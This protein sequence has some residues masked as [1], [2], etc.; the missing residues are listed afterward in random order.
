MKS[1]MKL[2]TIQS[3]EWYEE[4]LRKGTI[5]GQRSCI[6]KNWEFCLFGY[7]WLMQKMDERIGKRPN[8]DCY[9]V[10][11]WYQYFDE[12]KKKPD[13]RSRGFIPKGTK[14][15]RIEFVK[16]DKDVLLSDFMLWSF[17]FSY[18]SY[19]G[20]NERESLDFDK[21]LHEK[22]LYY[23]NLGQLPKD[24]RKEIVESWD[25]VLDLDYCDPYHASP[26]A[27]KSIQATF[28]TL[29]VDEIIKVEEF[30]AH[31]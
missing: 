27:K 11:A 20:K 23:K 22:G 31:R 9:P 18:Q 24:I 6:D 1:K 28:W 26:R 21:M 15:V 5:S 16:D 3:I 7:H 29:S 4:L 17:P 30:I 14:G 25:R 19:I 10:W 2:W 13:L 8:T 12:N